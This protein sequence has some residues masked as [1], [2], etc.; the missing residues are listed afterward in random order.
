M[1]KEKNNKTLHLVLKRKWWDMIA[2]GEKKEEYREVKPY[3]EKR[4]LNYK[5]LI[6]YYLANGAELKIKS[7][8]F[9]HR[10]VVEDVCNAFP[11]GFTR[12][13]FQ[14]GYRKDAPRMTFEIEEISIGKGREEWG[15][16]PDKLYFIIKLG[17][18]I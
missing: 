18:R 6:E 12:V 5:G 4:L 11:R 9:P 14:L 3:W 7:F 1:T 17:K 8:L 13:T 15:A 2:S 16:E 10:P